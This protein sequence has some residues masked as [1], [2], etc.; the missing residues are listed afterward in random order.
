MSWSSS[1]FQWTAALELLGPIRENLLREQ[2]YIGYSKM[3]RVSNYIKA[4]RH[5]AIRQSEP[6]QPRRQHPEWWPR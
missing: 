5:L 6:P 3:V 4:Q 1:R 2:D